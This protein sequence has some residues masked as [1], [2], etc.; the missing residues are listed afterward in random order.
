MTVQ[1]GYDFAKTSGGN[2]ESETTPLTKQGQE[3]H[4]GRTAQNSTNKER[5]I[6]VINKN[7][8]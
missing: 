7:D 8:L 3:R 4:L 5:S 2:G 6:P 1:V